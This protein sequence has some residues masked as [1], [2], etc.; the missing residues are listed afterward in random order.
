M[1]KIFRSKSSI[2]GISTAIAWPL[3]DIAKY[4][5]YQDIGSSPTLKK[6][7]SDQKLI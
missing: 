5:H 4:G 3:S 7:D 2:P 6:I 1:E